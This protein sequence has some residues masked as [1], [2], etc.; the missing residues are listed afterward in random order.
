MDAYGRS[1]GI[2]LVILNLGTRWVLSGLTPRP[3]RF[4]AEEKEPPLRNPLNRGC[5]GPRAGLVVF[6]EEKNLLSL[7]GIEH[8]NV[9]F[10]TYTH[11][12]ETQRKNFKLV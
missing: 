2:A 7:A 6:G 11:R 10:V 8:R 3:G 1:R 9:Q 4:T 12:T 5:V